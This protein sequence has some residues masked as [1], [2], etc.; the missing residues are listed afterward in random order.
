MVWDHC[1]KAFPKFEQSGKA[2]LLQAALVPYVFLDVT[3]G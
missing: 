1:V 3:T 2:D